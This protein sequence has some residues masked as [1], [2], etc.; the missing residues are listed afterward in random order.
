[1]ILLKKL[2]YT[3]VKTKI[4]NDQKINPNICHS[5]LPE[6]L[7][8]IKNKLVD[9]MRNIYN[10]LKME[11]ECLFKLNKQLINNFIKLGS[12]EKQKLLF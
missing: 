11:K 8:T 7:D 9:N 5:L 10:V 1:M 12:Y 2:F 3:I 4:T 6:K